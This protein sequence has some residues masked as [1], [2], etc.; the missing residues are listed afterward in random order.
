MMTNYDI[1]GIYHTMDGGNTWK[2]VEG[3]LTGSK[4]N[5]GPSIRSA[6]IVPAKSGTIY[7]VGTSTGVYS[8]RN[9]NGQNTKWVHVSP[10]GSNG[11]K[12]VIGYSIVEDITSRLSDGDVA[13]GTHGRGMF[14]GYFQGET[15]SKNVP[16]ISIKPKKG[17]AGDKVTITAQNFTFGSSPTV[18]FSGVPADV[19]NVTPSKIKVIVPR[20]T[21]APQSAK[22][23]NKN[24]VIVEVNRKHGID[25]TGVTFTIQ[26]PK[27][28]MLKQNYP[29]PFGVSGQTKIPISLKQTSNVTITIYDITGRRVDQPVKNKQYEAGTYNIPVDFS[30]HASGI[31]IYR[32]IAKSTKPGQKPFI[33]ARKFTYIK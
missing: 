20:A 1:V 9:F 32:I 4:T 6:T 13:V 23:P 2:A 33:K 17:R 18:T 8:T 28:N 3:N 26:S 24:K 22:R 15:V 7:L 30:G 31:Y 27:K 25:P 11:G 5:P 16:R 21:L 12:P 29:N 14:V 19:V 10:A